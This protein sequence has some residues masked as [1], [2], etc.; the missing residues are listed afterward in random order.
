MVEW[1]E[2]IK[3]Y[4]LV[5]E[6][7][8]ID[9]IVIT[10]VSSFLFTYANRIVV[11]IVKLSNKKGKRWYRTTQIFFR[12][13]KRM[14]K[15]ETLNLYEFLQLKERLENG[16]KLRCYEKKS[17][18]KSKRDHDKAQKKYGKTLS[19]IGKPKIDL[20]EIKNRLK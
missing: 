18:L 10:V 8:A 6:L 12:K 2:S 15:G 5:K 4:L 13:H 17:Y 7:R 20:N 11:A 14:A 19:N 9:V 1:F 3:E 16:G